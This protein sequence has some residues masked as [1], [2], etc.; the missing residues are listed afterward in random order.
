MTPEQRAQK[1]T[2]Q[3]SKDMRKKQ[4]KVGL[5][6][7]IAEA[8]RKAEKE[9][10]KHVCGLVNKKDWF[11]HAWEIADQCAANEFGYTDDVND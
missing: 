4:G 8:V 7:L 6:A 9:K 3:W 11:L 10:V 2:R 1:V 5:K